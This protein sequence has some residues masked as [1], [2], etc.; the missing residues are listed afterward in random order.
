MT[1]PLGV[2]GIQVRGGHRK[3]LFTLWVGPFPHWRVITA[4]SSDNIVSETVF[5][6]LSGLAIVF[7]FL[8]L[9]FLL[10]DLADYI[11]KLYTI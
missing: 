1:S 6:D 2:W 5:Q 7:G 4:R 11:R 8:F 9:F 3:L 10:T